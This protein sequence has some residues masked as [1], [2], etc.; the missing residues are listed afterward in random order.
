VRSL[1]N[2]TISLTY[3]SGEIFAEINDATNF[4]KFRSGNRTT[5]DFK[6]IKVGTELTI[7]GILDEGNHTVIAR[8]V[9]D[10]IRRFQLAGKVTSIKK[11]LI[12][13]S[14]NG[15]DNIIDTST[16]VTVKKIGLKRE[17]TPG[18]IADIAIGD[19][20]SA[21]GYFDDGDPNLQALKVLYIP[22]SLFTT[23]S[24]IPTPSVSPTASPSGKVKN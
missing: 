9:I 8:Q 3:D 1:G 14:S 16:V 24:P 21:L 18:R 15:T 5:S 4:Y 2:N 23:P 7:I 17:L 10:K 19:F 6:S 20:V 11:E 13:V 22:Q 12:T